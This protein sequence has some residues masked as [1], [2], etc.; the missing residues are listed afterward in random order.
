MTDLPGW[1]AALTGKT[2]KASATAAPSLTRAEAAAEV[3]RGLERF[4]PIVDELRSASQR[5]YAR[6]NIHYDG[7]SVQAILLPH[8]ACVKQAT[9]LFQ[10]RASAE[11][12]LGQTDQ[13][14]ADT[15][16]AL[17]LA[18]TPKD[19]AAV[20]CG[21]LYLLGDVINAVEETK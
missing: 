9:V 4:N 1:A 14:W 7:D 20:C 19:G 21:S 6:F 10:V 15:K 17:Y 16:M 18:D 2:N 5:P 11:L 12:A 3:L 13:A 8:L